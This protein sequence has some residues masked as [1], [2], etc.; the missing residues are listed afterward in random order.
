MVRVTYNYFFFTLVAVAILLTNACGINQQA[1]Q[2]KALE[3][4]E[5]RVKEVDSLFV[6]GTDVLPMIK[7]GRLDLSRM[8]GIALGMLSKDIPMQGVVSVNIKNPTKDLAGIN[9]FRYVLLVDGHEVADGLMDQKIAVE[10]GE[11]HI[12][13]VRVNANVY[14]LLSDR[15]LLNRIVSFVSSGAHNDE[16]VLTIKL[17]PTLA[18]G[19]KSVNYPGWISFDRKINRQLFLKD[20]R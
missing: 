13:P 12:Y 2:I 16:A 3:N 19:N 9:Q 6:A 8:G 20:M 1:K 7:N 17:K 15:A 14:G 10:G 11:E 18:L 4:C 5:Y